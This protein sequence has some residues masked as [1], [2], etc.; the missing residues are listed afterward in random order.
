MTI[1]PSFGSYPAFSSPTQKHGPLNAAPMISIFGFISVTPLRQPLPGYI[2]SS[3]ALR[4]IS[5]PFADD[6]SLNS[7]QPL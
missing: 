4:S 2:I 7:L 6:L 3:R 1:P 5:R